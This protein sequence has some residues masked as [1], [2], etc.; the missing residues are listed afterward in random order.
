MDVKKIKSLFSYI[1]VYYPEFTREL[2]NEEL[3]RMM[4]AWNKL[5][6]EYKSDVLYK[7]V[8]RY[9]ESDIYRRPPAIGNLKYEIINISHV[10]DKTPEVA[11]ES[12]IRACK[13]PDKNIAYDNLDD[14]TKRALGGIEGI[15]FIKMQ[16]IYDELPNSR[17]EF[18]KR[19]D[20]LGKEVVREKVVEEAYIK[21]AIEF[22]FEMKKIE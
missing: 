15:Y 20:K 21:N 13:A 11:W 7:A 12:V 5:L 18:I 17:R 19:Y 16:S 22:G 8:D 10:D 2:T 3:K 4:V 9:V 1:S 6:G 14:R